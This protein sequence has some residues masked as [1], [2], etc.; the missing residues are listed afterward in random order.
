MGSREQIVD[1]DDLISSRTSV[2]DKREAIEF[3]MGIADAR[4]ATLASNP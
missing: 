3:K 4:R 1:L 2:S